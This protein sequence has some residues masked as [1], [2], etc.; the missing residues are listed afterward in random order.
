MSRK[1]KDKM[2]YCL[3]CKQKV[4]PKKNILALI[5]FIFAFIFIIGF[6]SNLGFLI[7][8][9]LR[10]LNPYLDAGAFVFIILIGILLVQFFIIKKLIGYGRTN[11]TTCPM[12]NS[13]N[14]KESKEEH[15][16]KGLSYK[17]KE[18]FE[19]DEK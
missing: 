2:K 14:W 10:A 4:T 5:S 3:N 16:D 1:K 17:I 7:F 9:V 19:E 13:R 6:L 18:L 12:C 15:K 11:L 8:Y